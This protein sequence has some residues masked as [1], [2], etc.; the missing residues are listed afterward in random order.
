MGRAEAV[1]YSGPT[2]VAIRSGKH[3][4]STASTHAVDFEKVTTLDNF[5]DIM[6]VEDGRLKPVKYDLDAVFLF[7]NAPGRSAFNRVERRM[8]PLSRE[9]SG[10][11]LPH[12]SCGTHLDERGRTIDHDLEKNNFQKAGEVL[13]EVWNYVVID[14]HCVVAEFVEPD[15]IAE[16]SVPDMP[17]PQ[18]YTEH[19]RESQY[20]LQI[21]K[22]D[23]RVCCGPLR[24]SLRSVLPVR[25]LLPPYPISQTSS[26]LCILKPQEHDGKT[27]ANFLLRRA[28]LIAPT[29]EGFMR[30]PY[31]LYCPSLQKDRKL[32]VERICQQC[33]QYFCTK[34]RAKECHGHHTAHETPTRILTLRGREVLCVVR[35]DDDAEW[36]DETEVNTS[37]TSLPITTASEEEALPVVTLNESL[38]TPWDEDNI[39]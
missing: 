30:M 1:T 19:V 15:D 6:R 18:W 4:S 28:L 13:A 22:C 8:A 23:D 33:G 5:K 7:T 24:S 3:S 29:H 17:S 20:F 37:R 21:V 26:G 36:L 11:I 2:Y 16:S 27:F 38:A 32:L 34:K 14:N 31:D 25:F 12:D 9:L 35:E 39:N 10:L